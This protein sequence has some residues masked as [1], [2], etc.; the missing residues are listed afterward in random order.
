MRWNEA[1]LCQARSDRAALERLNH[2]GVDDCHRLHYLQMLTEKLAKA[3]LCG[4]DFPPPPT[5][6]AFVRML[7]IIKARPDIRRRLGFRSAKTFSRY[8]D[9]LLSLA[10]R[11]EALAP[12]IAGADSPNAEYPWRDVATAEVISPARFD[13]VAFR[14]S[15]LRMQKL[16]ALVDVLLR[17][18]I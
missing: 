13:F 3:R 10:A 9:S 7:Q 8:I 12:A 11:I 17:I 18:D 16:M 14:Q 1:F 15:D 4:P 5:H 2:F 6:G